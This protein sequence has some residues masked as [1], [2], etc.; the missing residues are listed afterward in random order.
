MRLIYSKRSVKDLDHIGSYLEERN[1]HAAS[2]VVSRIRSLILHLRHLPEMG[3]VQNSAGIRMLVDREF[4]YLI[5]YRRCVR[6][7]AIEIITVRHG[8]QRRIVRK[9]K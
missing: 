2:R 9:T 4:G 1:P 3:A 8:R 6:L 5:Y 7:E